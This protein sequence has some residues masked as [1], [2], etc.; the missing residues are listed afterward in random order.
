MTADDFVSAV[1]G[2][3]FDE[4]GRSWTLEVD[5]IDDS[6]PMTLAIT[7]CIPE[8]S[9]EMHFDA[10]RDGE[11]DVAA[12]QDHVVGIARDIVAGRQQSGIRTRL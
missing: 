4:N 3:A 10:S 9:Q 1:D 5:D 11:L 6:D 7:I 8:A 2:L 12:L